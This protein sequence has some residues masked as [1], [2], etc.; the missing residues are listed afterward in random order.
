MRS[1]R[2][3]SIIL[4]FMKRHINFII[5]VLTLCVCNFFVYKHNTANQ[6]PSKMSD[7]EF[8]SKV[9]AWIDDEVIYDENGLKSL[10]PDE[11]VVDTIETIKDLTDR[12]LPGAVIRGLM[13]LGI[14]VA[15]KLGIIPGDALI[16]LF[17]P[18]GKGEV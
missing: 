9:G 14:K 10:A 16:P 3:V 12:S 13:P 5:A 17:P 15:E 4:Y 2:L 8:P 7:K 18:L 11:V 6:N 1:P